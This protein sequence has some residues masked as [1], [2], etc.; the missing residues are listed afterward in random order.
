MRKKWNVVTLI[1]I[2]ALSN[3]DHQVCY[4]PSKCGELHGGVNLWK[5]PD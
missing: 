4:L 2:T 5:T 1:A 3:A